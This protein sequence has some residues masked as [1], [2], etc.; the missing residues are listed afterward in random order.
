MVDRH[1]LHLY[2]I[3]GLEWGGSGCFRGPCEMLKFA[4]TPE[5]VLCLQTKHDKKKKFPFKRKGLPSFIS[6]LS[7]C[8]FKNAN[9]TNHDPNLFTQFPL[10]QIE[11]A[12]I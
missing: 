8:M 11:V 4:I 3:N 7:L 10:F 6:D 9:A 12:S 2:Y 5:P 1:V